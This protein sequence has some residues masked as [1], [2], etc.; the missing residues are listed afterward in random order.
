MATDFLADVLE[1]HK[2][3]GVPFADHPRRGKRARV[4]LRRDL[5]SEEYDELIEAID[6]LE[7]GAETS[8]H[9]EK[10]MA[11]TAKE[12]A[13]LI[14]VCVGT[15]LELGIPL[16]RVWAEVHRSNMTKGGEPRGDGKILKGP[17]YQPPN[18]AAALWGEPKG[19]CDHEC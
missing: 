16:D 9:V 5:I 2:R 10:W 1:F 11:A 18:I 3:F 13:D 17:N 19:D 7:F 6:E 14:Y 12:L 15:A 8:P 4:A